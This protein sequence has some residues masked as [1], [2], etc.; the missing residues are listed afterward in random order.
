MFEPTSG[1][2]NQSEKNPLEKQTQFRLAPILIVITLA[3]LMING[4]RRFP[5]VILTPMAVALNLS[6]ADL[7]YVLSAQWALT[8]L[9]PFAGAYIDRIGRKR[10]MLIGIGIL[11]LF[12][13]LAAFGQTPSLVILALL[14]GAFSKIFYDPAMQAYIGDRVPYRQ[15]GMA[16]GITELAWSGALF[17]LGPLASFLIAREALNMIFLVLALGSGLSLFFMV[18]L[19]P[20][21]PMQPRT[22]QPFYTK[23]GLVWSNRS[24]LAV[25]TAAILMSIAI[26]S[27]QIGYEAYLTQAFNMS[28]AALGILALV[29]SVA[30]V[31]GEGFV[32]VMADRLGKRRLVIAGLLGTGIMCFLVPH[33]PTDFL[34]GGAMFLMFLA[35]EIS[36]VAQIPLA[37]EVLPEARGTLLSMN[38]AS[39]ATGR[40]IGTILGGLLFR[41]GGYELNGT[42]GLII[43]VIAAVILWRFAIEHREQTVTESIEP[44]EAAVIS[45][46]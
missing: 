15:R 10:M 17:I 40:A 45:A 7:E 21:E 43:N 26:E 6:R 39:F 32:I 13:A 35:L 28:L 2:P 34:T 14:A 5:Y 3:R 37:S 19:L 46:E 20:N 41:S 1:I 27:M 33:M 11:A 23:F 4:V 12:S 30:E 22:G 24:A 36:V 31:S 8:I 29:F 44:Q 16:I 38:V 18:R 25:L 42:V 9:S